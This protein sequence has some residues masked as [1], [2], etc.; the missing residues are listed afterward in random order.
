LVQVL[1]TTLANAAPAESPDPQL[2]AAADQLPQLLA[3]GRRDEAQELLAKLRPD[4]QEPVATILDDL[5]TALSR[6]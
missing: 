1:A 2:Q 4:Q 6:N 3:S 5:I